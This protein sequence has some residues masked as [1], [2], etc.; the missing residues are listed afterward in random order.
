MKNANQ[1]LLYFYSLRKERGVPPSL[2]ITILYSALVHPNTHNASLFSSSSNKGLLLDDGLTGWREI[3]S[4]S[5]Q[6]SSDAT[7]TLYPLLQKMLE[8]STQYP[9]SLYDYLLGMNVYRRRH[10]LYILIHPYPFVSWPFA[11]T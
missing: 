9:Y 11:S 5:F 10:Q 2:W 8:M 7:S 1:I 6:D 4:M 3:L